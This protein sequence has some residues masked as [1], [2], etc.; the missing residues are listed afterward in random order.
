MK[1]EII[2][3]K[4]EKL[5]S[6]QQAEQDMEFLTKNELLKFGK[7]RVWTGQKTKWKVLMPRWKWCH[8]KSLSFFFLLLFLTCVAMVIYKY[9]RNVSVC[10][11]F[12]KLSILSHRPTWTKI[13]ISIH[14]GLRVREGEFQGGKKRC[15]VI[16]WLPLLWLKIFRSGL[17]ICICSCYPSGKI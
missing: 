1:E 5:Q 15:L 12:W 6:H 14:V 10:D 9:P 8:Q 4:S 3:L 16:C 13:L 7:R 2:D 11:L 17:D